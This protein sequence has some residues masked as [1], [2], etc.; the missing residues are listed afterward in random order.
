MAVA[1]TAPDALKILWKEKAFVEEQ[2]IA[3]V[4]QKLKKRGYNFTKTN[5]S[6]ALKNVKFL[7]RCGNRGKFKYIQKHPYSEE[8]ENDKRRETS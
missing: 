3:S 5:L 8:A 1:K 7:T 2:D 6:M 4:K